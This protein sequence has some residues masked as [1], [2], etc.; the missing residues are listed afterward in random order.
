MVLSSRVAAFA[1]AKVANM[2][3]AYLWLLALTAVGGSRTGNVSPKTIA[4]ESQPATV[5]ATGQAKARA[6]LSAAN[7][8][9]TE[10]RFV[11]AV[12]SGEIDHVKLFLAAGMSPDTVDAEQFSVLGM[13]VVQHHNEVVRVLLEAGAKLRDDT[14]A[15]SPLG[16]ARMSSNAEAEA[17]L[18]KRG[19]TLLPKEQAF[20]E[21]LKRRSG[22]SKKQI[23]EAIENGWTEIVALQ[24]KTGMDL[25]V[26]L[27]EGNTPLHIAAARGRL[28]I[29]R[30]LIQSGADV[31]ARNKRGTPVIGY[32]I[33]QKHD[34]VVRLL[35][36]AGARE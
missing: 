16:L 19:A 14:W 13:A 32:A 11:A 22:I 17:L 24:L 4:H 36:E 30:L 20:E 35:T 25:R 27:F 7:V 34:D 18:Q 10:T 12:R 2:R 31:N 26:D 8:E 1:T 29:A 21:L 23:F 9:F 15:G 33:A 5:C 3:T 6:R 28:D